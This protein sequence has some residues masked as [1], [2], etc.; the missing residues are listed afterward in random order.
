[1]KILRENGYF[2]A[3]YP[4]HPRW[5]DMDPKVYLYDCFGQFVS[6]VKVNLY[7][8]LLFGDKLV[9]KDYAFVN[10]FGVVHFWKLKG[11]I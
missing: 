8:D 10:D 5:V 9:Y 1:M 4:Y 3:V 11:C 7:A 6:E 2:V